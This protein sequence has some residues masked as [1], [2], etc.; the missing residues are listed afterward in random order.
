MRKTIYTIG[1][2]KHPIAE[3]IALLKMHEITAVADVRSRP[4]SRFNPHFNKDRLRA[5]LAEAGIEYVFLGKELGARPEDPDCYVGNRV[6][7]SRLAKTELFEQG[8]QRL[9]EGVK[10][11]W[12]A[13]MCAEKDPLN[14]HRTMLVSRELVDRGFTVKHILADGS[15]QSYAKSMQDLVKLLKLEKDMFASREDLVKQALDM[16][17]GDIAYTRKGA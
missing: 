7:F 9:R 12:V 4:Y 8:I 11:Y 15:V 17:S 3:F 10:K 14:C 1:H 16:R 2:S 5:S 13:M 6:V